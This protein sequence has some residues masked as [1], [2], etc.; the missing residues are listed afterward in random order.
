MRINYDI[1]IFLFK[2][3]KLLLFTIPEPPFISDRQRETKQKEKDV[4][5]HE[6][7]SEQPVFMMWKSREGF[8]HVTMSRKDV[9]LEESKEGLINFGRERMLAEKMSREEFKEVVQSRTRKVVRRDFAPDGGV[10]ETI[11]QQSGEDINHL[12]G[13]ENKES[14]RITSEK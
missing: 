5:S 3:L 11:I 7:E 13:M 12:P 10:I 2:C 4:G 9:Q 6:S 8:K 14:W 1:C